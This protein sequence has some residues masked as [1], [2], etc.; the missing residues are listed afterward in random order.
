MQNRVRR[1][2]CWVLFLT[3]VIPLR[4]IAQDA[5][6]SH[7]RLDL[8][9]EQTAFEPGRKIWVGVLF[10][11]DPG[12]HVYWKNPG[13][14]GTPPVIQWVLPPGFHAGALRWP[15]P[16][17]LGSGSVIDYGYTDQVLLMAP[18]TAPVMAK[19]TAAI[20]ANVKYVVC[21]EV[22]IPGKKQLSLSIPP[23]TAQGDQLSNSGNLFQSTR[24]Q[25]PKPIPSS[26]KI[27]TLAAKNQFELN[28]RGALVPNQSVSFFPLEPDV[29]DNA[30]PQ[31]MTPANG[32]FDLALRVSELVRKTPAVLNGVLTVPGLGAYEVS[33][34]VVVKI[35]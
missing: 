14:S 25:F 5:P 21:R 11:L 2:L 4:L 8:V 3:S 12:W 35:H 17:R 32:G 20:A 31:V 24:E 22:C 6:A 15:V 13:D 7:A 9:A 19:G 26:W 16:V 29:I 23:A 1:L 10:H 34:P 27:S 30:S 18:I 33:A 28:V